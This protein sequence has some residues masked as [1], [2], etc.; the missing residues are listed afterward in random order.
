MLSKKGQNIIIIASIIADVAI[1]AAY[2]QTVFDWVG[3]MIDWI[4]DKIHPKCE[5]NE[6]E[7]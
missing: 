3:T 4:D 1:V 6:E 5:V 2:Y 7:F